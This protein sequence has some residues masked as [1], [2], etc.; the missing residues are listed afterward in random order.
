MVSASLDFSPLQSAVGQLEIALKQAQS[1]P[2]DDVVRDGAIQRFEYPY[3]L[4]MKFI[5]RVLEVIFADAV[6]PLAYRDLLRTAAERGL[7]ADV[8]QWF[9]YRD[10]RN[11]TSHTYDGKVAAEVFRVIPSFLPDAKALLIRFQEL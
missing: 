8:E 10:A 5:K 9:L 2:D 6:D 7:I 4:A 11:K 1:N 3:E